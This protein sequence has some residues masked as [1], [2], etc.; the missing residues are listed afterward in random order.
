VCIS[1]KKA[2]KTVHAEDA[3]VLDKLYYQPESFG[4]VKRLKVLS[5]DQ[6]QRPYTRVKGESF[7]SADS[8]VE[9]E[10]IPKRLQEQILYTE[11]AAN[12]KNDKGKN[13]LIILHNSKKHYQKQVPQCVQ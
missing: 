12:A 10:T 11:V 7:A 9:I 1:K 6:N 4:A 2:G 8:S 5:P 3:H 13:G